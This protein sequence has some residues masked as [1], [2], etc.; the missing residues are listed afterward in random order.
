[1]G[2]G[3][4]R[5]VGNGHLVYAALVEN[6][7]RSRPTVATSDS[8]RRCLGSEPEWQRHGDNIYERRDSVWRQ[9][10]NPHHKVA[11]MEHDLDGRCVLVSTAF[12]YLVE[13][14]RDYLP[15][16]RS[17]VKIGPGH[18]RNDDVAKERALKF[19]LRRF[20]PGVLGIPAMAMSRGKAK[21]SAKLLA[22]KRSCATRAAG[23][24]D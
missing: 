9:R 2:T 22:E 12:W 16:S 13:T 14:L 21:K 6:R 8:S 3:S 19:W 20:R 10:R 1:M 15:T 4:R 5:G 11:N 7:S 18:K 17:S 23:H 24:R